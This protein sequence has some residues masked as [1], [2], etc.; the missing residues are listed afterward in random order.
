MKCSLSFLFSF[1]SVLFLSAQD[2][3]PAIDS[4]LAARITVS[5]FCLCRTTVAGLEQLDK[6]LAEVPVEEMDLGK[7][8]MVRNNDYINGKG[9]YSAA[10]PGMIFQQDQGTEYISKIRLTKG[11]RGKLPDGCFVD[12]DHLRLRD[13][14]GMYPGL[15]DKWGSRDCS[16]FWSFSKDTIVFYVRIDST[17]KP[18]YPI[19]EAYYLDRP[20]EG[21]DLVI[22]CYSILHPDNQTS[23]FNPDQPAYFLDSIRTNAGFLTASGITPSEIAFINVLKGADAVERAGKAGANGVVDIITKKYAR[24][25]YWEY[26]TSKSADYRNKVPDL[27]TE[28]DV[29]YILNGKVLEKDRESKLFAIHDDNFTGLEVTSRE[30]LEKTYHI[31]GKAVGVII[32]TK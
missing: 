27:K 26:F 18:Q 4:A 9:Y 5:G 2:N 30:S 31:Y 17:K 7:R 29:V 20:V 16:D 13:V 32:K 25:H 6:H 22:S 28:A 15:K 11:F 1:L 8:C 3:Q 23:L 12:L 19:D 24:E 14:F 21:I 10:Y